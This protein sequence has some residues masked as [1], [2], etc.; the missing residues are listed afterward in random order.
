MPV[1][2]VGAEKLSD[3]PRTVQPI[4]HK[5]GEKPFLCSFVDTC[6]L[7]VLLP[8]DTPYLWAIAG[9][10]GVSSLLVSSLL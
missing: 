3:K 1:I 10:R 2:G 5:L 9:H 4:T 7:P 8:V 6:P